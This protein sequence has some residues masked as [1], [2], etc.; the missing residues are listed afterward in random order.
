MAASQVIVY[1]ESQEDA[2]LFTLA[3]SSVLGEDGR[4]TNREDLLKVGKEIGKASRI[5][6]RGALE[7]AS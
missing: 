4:I 1:F 3:A 7:L 5:T 2:L 6:T